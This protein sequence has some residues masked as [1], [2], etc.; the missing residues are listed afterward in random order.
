MTTVRPMTML[1]LAYVLNNLRD[2]DKRELLEMH[3]HGN[4]LG[5]AY[6]RLRVSDKNDAVTIFRDDLP[7]VVFGII[8]EV[9]HIAHSWAFGTE[10]TKYVFKTYLKEAK[11][12]LLRQ[13]Y[14]RIYTTSPVYRP[15]SHRVLEILGYEKEGMLK[16]FGKSGN[17]F[18]SFV[19]EGI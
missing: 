8:E 18:I 2:K 3:Y 19:Y 14:S 10:E 7:V 13:K 17:N 5:N 4:Y 1:D 11:Q 12:M 6:M 9:P 16:R 15:E